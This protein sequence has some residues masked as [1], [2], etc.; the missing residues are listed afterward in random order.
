MRGDRQN[1]SRE[2]LSRLVWHPKIR[3]ESSRGGINETAANDLAEAERN[4]N[5]VS[6]ARD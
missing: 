2:R 5:D 1:I 6:N 4:R 3:M